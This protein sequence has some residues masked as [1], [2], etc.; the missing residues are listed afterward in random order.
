[1]E[2]NPR[3]EMK[4]SDMHRLQGGNQVNQESA[5]PV[6]RPFSKDY[7]CPSFIPM[8]VRWRQGHTLDSDCLRDINSGL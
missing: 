3:R 2:P 7:M 8:Q 6:K 1:M 4:V 5:A